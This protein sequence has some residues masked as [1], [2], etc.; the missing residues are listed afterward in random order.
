MKVVLKLR[1]DR[2]SLIKANTHLSQQRNYL[3][4]QLLQMKDFQ[5]T[6]DRY[7]EANLF[8]T[9]MATQSTAKIKELNDKL[10]ERNFNVSL[11]IKQD[12]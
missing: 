5:R 7:A 2:D 8:L 6:A 11:T 1:K 4:N 10:D 3:S 9:K 12:K